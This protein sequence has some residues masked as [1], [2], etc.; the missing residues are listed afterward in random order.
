M[1]KSQVI[2]SRDEKAL[3]KEYGIG[4]EEMTRFILR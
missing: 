3:L 1:Q 4:V 2:L